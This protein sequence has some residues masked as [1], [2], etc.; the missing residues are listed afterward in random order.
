MVTHIKENTGE[1]VAGKSHGLIP[2]TGRFFHGEQL[3]V[4]VDAQEI[5]IYI[6]LPE[7]S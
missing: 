7:S 6:N 2:E 1:R 4:G 5:G 3:A